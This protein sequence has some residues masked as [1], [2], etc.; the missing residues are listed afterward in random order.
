MSIKIIAAH[1]SNRIIGHK[2]G[3]PW[4]IKGELRRFRDIT[5]NHNVV[6]GRKTYESIGKV[7]DGRKNIIVSSNNKFRVDGAISASSYDD[8][9]SKCDPEKDIFIIGGAKL[10]ELALGHCDYLLL[11]LI[12]KKIEGDTYFPKYDD[13]SWTLINEVRNYDLENKFSYTYLTYKV[14]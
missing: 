12:N 2:G 6:M 8:A 11:T 13:S 3:I 4:F 5:M 1:S 7:L 14:Q 9:L 10:Y